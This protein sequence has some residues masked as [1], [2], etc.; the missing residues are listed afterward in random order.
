[1]QFKKALK[2]SG[3]L[4]RF[5]YETMEKVTAGTIDARTAMTAAKLA[6]QINESLKVEVELAIRGQALGHTPNDPGAMPLYSEALPD[7][8]ALAP[9][10][11]PANRKDVTSI[12]MGDPP[13]GRSALDQKR[14]QV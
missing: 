5:L 6:A 12:A 10:R 13:P 7:D 3:D 1:M 11:A 9:P 8:R 14:N 4:R 2:T